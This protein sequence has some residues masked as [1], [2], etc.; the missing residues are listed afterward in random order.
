MIY[1]GEQIG[2][3]T[4]ET[5]QE[6]IDSFAYKGYKLSATK[7]QKAIEKNKEYNRN[8]DLRNVIAGYIHIQANI[9][10]IPMNSLEI[11]MI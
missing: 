8:K 5:I 1:K 3:P 6:V 9:L 4:L 7:I 10:S 2:I 11:S